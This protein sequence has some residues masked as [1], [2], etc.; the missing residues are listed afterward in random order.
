MKQH[1]FLLVYE[2]RSVRYSETQRNRL[3]G[4]DDA[5]YFLTMSNGSDS[6]MMA[7]ICHRPFSSSSAF[8]HGKWRT[9]AHPCFSDQIIHRHPTSVEKESARYFPCRFGEY[10]V[11]CFIDLR[12]FA[13]LSS[14]QVLDYSVNYLSYW[15]GCRHCHL[16]LSLRSV[17]I[18][19]WLTVGCIVIAIDVN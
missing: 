14:D 18:Y 16:S 6:Q 5:K 7:V 12:L 9:T 8:H 3:R 15:C 19:C 1:K 10:W 11:A 17:M 4:P 13:I 2:M